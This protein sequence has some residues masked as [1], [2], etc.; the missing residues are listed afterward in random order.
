[1]V[2]AAR[3]ISEGVR[4]DKIMYLLYVFERQTENSVDPDQTPLNAASDQGL[5]C[6]PLIQQFYTLTG[7]KSDVLKKEQRCKY[8]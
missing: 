8:L 3:M 4:V 2:R 6:L 5:H 7:S 1:M